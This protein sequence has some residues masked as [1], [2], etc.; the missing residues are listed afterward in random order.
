MFDSK[1]YEYIF[2]DRHNMALILKEKE[3]SFRRWYNANKQ[4]LSEERKKRYAQDPEYRQRQL[5]SS[6]RYRRGER[7][8]P[9]P[10]AAPISFTQAAERTGIGV[11]T[12]HE[13]QKKQY[14]P[15]PQ[16]HNR[17]LWFSEK[18][19]FLLKNLKDRVYKKRRWYMKSDRFQE[20]I[21]S[22]FGNWE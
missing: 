22:T 11:T 7:C 9:N 18:Q 2:G 8:L 15:E 4:R 12:L 16:H 20:V 21:A 3:S 13:W 1:L 6:K 10:P 19:V 5:E 14:F 17:G